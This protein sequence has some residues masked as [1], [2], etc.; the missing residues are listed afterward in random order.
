[1][2][3]IAVVASLFMRFVQRKVWNNIEPGGSGLLKTIQ[4]AVVGLALV[5]GAAMAFYPNPAFVPSE[6]VDDSYHL[7]P[8]LQTEA[9]APATQKTI[10]AEE[11]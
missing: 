6:A 2:V 10:N 9:P 4:Y 3:V 11:E 8:R 7:V 5:M 1:M